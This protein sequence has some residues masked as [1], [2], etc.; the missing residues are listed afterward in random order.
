MPD[1]PRYKS[2]L[3]ETAEHAFYNCERVRQFWN[4]VREGTAC[5]EPKQLM[6][7]DVGYLVD[8]V[9]PQ[10]N[11]LTF[12]PAVNRETGAS[13]RRYHLDMWTGWI[14]NCDAHKKQVYVIQLYNP[15][16]QTVWVSWSQLLL[17]LEL[18]FKAVRT[19]SQQRAWALRTPGWAAQENE[20]RSAAIVRGTGSQYVAVCSVS[21]SPLTYIQPFHNPFA[22]LS[23]KA[24]EV[25]FSKEVYSFVIIVDYVSAYICIRIV[26]SRLYNNS[27]K[28]RSV[29]FFSRS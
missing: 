15:V 14:C 19:S 2:S 3:K 1:C 20:K 29:W 7:L 26:V 18:Q 21:Y 17:K 6:L 23:N 4:H 24:W 16:P 25:Y 8:K 12:D 28:V 27:F 5:I 13:G 10:C 22:T 9:L 11:I